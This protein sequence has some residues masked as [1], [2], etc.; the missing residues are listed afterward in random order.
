MRASSEPYAD[1]FQLASVTA[2]PGALVQ[3]LIDAGLKRAWDPGKELT[4]AFYQ[5]S[6]ATDGT[7]GNALK[8]QTIPIVLTKTFF[9][10]A[11]DGIRGGTVT[12]VQTCALPI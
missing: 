1:Y 4:L 8:K 3:T 9:F 11:E 10:Q 7:F 2:N 12:G 6:S 5:L